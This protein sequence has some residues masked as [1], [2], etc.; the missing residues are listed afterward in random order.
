MESKKEKTGQALCVAGLSAR[1][2]EFTGHIRM[3]PVPDGTDCH[4]HQQ[5]CAEASIFHSRNLDPNPEKSFKC[6]H[7]V[8]SYSN[9]YV[10]PSHPNWGAYRSILPQSLT[11]AA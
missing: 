11:L 10:L 4:G 7:Y 6:V 8:Q 3:R 5:S 2:L 1:L 9:S